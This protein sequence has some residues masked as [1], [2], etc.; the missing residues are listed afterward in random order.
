MIFDVYRNYWIRS[1]IKKSLLKNEV[2]FSGKPQSALILYRVDEFPDLAN[3]VKW[4]KQL[5]IKQGNITFVGY[6]QKPS[7][8]PV[9]GVIAFTHASVSRLGGVT[10]VA[11]QKVLDAS[12]DVLINYYVTDRLEL[13]WLSHMINAPCKVSLGKSAQESSDLLIDVPS[14]EVSSFITELNKYLN[15]IAK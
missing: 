14:T 8:H 1:Q 15:V 9:D 10:D 7:Q 13:S 5:E 4:A 12:Y 11:V 3:Q 6:S 2:S